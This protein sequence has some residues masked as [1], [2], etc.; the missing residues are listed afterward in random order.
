MIVERVLGNIHTANYKHLEVDRVQMEWYDTGKRIALLQS[1]N[2]QTLAMRLANVPKHGLKDGD[3]LFQDSRRIIIITILPTLALSIQIQDWESI[4]RVCYEIGNLHIP[5]FFGRNNTE[6][7]AP[8]EKP[9][10]RALEKLCIPFEKEMYIL[11][12]KNRIYM[13][14]PFIAQEPR[15][16][17]NSNFTVTVTRKD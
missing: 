15:L 9:L 1:E 14:S 3:I 17:R 13:A 11:D 10:Q 12:N 16:T 6:L 8:F 4:V 7:Q 2:G 5:L